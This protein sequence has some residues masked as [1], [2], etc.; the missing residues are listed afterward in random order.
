MT[1]A[2]SLVIAAVSALAL[3]VGAPAHVSEKTPAWLP[4]P[5]L[6]A[7]VWTALSLI[8]I[9]RKFTTIITIS[10]YMLISLCISAVMLFLLF[11]AKAY[12]G[13][14]VKRGLFI[15]GGISWILLCVTVIPDIY[16]EFISET[17]VFTRPLGYEAALLVSMLLF[18]PITLSLSLRGVEE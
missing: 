2:L 11:A 12:A 1:I 7:T 5:L 3:F 14:P 17:V 8:N 16:Y 4:A 9:Y 10:D 15:W 13:R 18:I 6:G